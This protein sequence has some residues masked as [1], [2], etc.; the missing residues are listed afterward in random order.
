LRDGT[1]YS[2]QASLNVSESLACCLLSV[3]PPAI[4][5]PTLWGQACASVDVRLCSKTKLAW[6]VLADK[7]L[8]Q[9]AP[10]HTVALGNPYIFRTKVDVSADLFLDGRLDATQQLKLS[11]FL[12]KSTTRLELAP[13]NRTGCDSSLLA[14]TTPVLFAADDLHL[15]ITS[16]ARTG[17]SQHLTR[18]EVSDLLGQ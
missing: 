3:A 2:S 16:T 12:L 15:R 10:K 5:R 11:L 17:G 4:A 13:G 9:L 1:I 14:H 8:S 7:P 18:L 6:Q